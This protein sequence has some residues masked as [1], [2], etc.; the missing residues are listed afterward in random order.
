MPR[1]TTCCQ[2]CEIRE[3]P[4]R[5]SAQSSHVSSR[6]RTNRSSCGDHRATIG[7]RRQSVLAEG[8]RVRLGP[9]AKR[10]LPMRKTSSQL[11][12]SQNPSDSSCNG[13]VGSARSLLQLRTRWRLTGML[14]DDGRKWDGCFESCAFITGYPKLVMKAPVD[15][16]SDRWLMARANG[17]AHGRR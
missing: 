16:V 3:P 11:V 9:E 12:S 13:I 1:V 8:R 17:K 14:Q 2:A 10:V 5:V 15:G 4:L 7:L 6:R